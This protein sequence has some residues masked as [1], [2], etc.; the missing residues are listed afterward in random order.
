MPTCIESVRNRAAAPGVLHDRKIIA[1]LYGF[2]VYLFFLITFLYT[3]GFVEGIPGIKTID[4]GPTDETW[5]AVV[6]NVLLLGLFCGTGCTVSWRARV[7]SVSG[8]G[9][10]PRRSSAPRMS[11]RLASR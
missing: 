3:I 6:I 8:R 10:C 9:L 1:L 11:W 5:V 4:N 2:V 7:L